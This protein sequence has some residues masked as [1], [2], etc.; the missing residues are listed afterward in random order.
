MV[1][2]EPI[3]EHV[4]AALHLKGYFD[5]PQLRL[6]NERP[7]FLAHEEGSS[8]LVAL[9]NFLADSSASE[10]LVT[11]MSAVDAL[12]NMLLALLYTCLCITEERRELCSVT[13]LPEPSLLLQEGVLHGLIDLIELVVFSNHDKGF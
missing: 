8:C 7:L 10:Q 2:P 3:K 4:G 1:R 12:V 9:G 5:L 13:L 6:R 11:H